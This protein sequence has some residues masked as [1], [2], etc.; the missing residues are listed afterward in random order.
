[1]KAE[2]TKILLPR[3]V[4]EAN[5]DKD[6]ELEATLPDFQPDINRVVRAD[7]EIFCEENA[8]GDGK[9]KVQ[10]KA[11]FTVLYES[12]SGKLRCEQFSSDFSHSFDTGVLPDG[13][14]SPT[15]SARCSFVSCKTLNPR[16]FLLRCRADLGLC[17]RCMQSHDVVSM[18]D[19]KDA[20]FKSVVL[21]N[22]EYKDTVRRDYNM[23]ESFSLE[24]M[25][26]IKEIVA[27]SMRF[28]PAEQSCN[29]GSLLLRCEAVFRCL[30]EDDTDTLNTVERRFP[31]VFTVEDPDINC[32][33]LLSV[34]VIPTKCN[35]H[36][37]MD[38]YGEYRQI[39]LE[40][41]AAVCVESVASTETKLP[42][43]MFFENYVNEN[44]YTDIPYEQPQR[45]TV[46]RFTEEKIFDAAE[47]LPDECLDIGTEIVIN[48]AI[49][50]ND[51]VTINGICNVSIFG[52]RDGAFCAKD[53][54][55]PFSRLIPTSLP[56]EE[57]RIKAK[58]ELVSATARAS[59]SGVTV[60]V[61]YQTVLNVS[62]NSF[63]RVISGADIE[64]RSDST[65]EA[66]MIICYPAP[67]E[68]AW[69][70]AKRYYVNPDVLCAENEDV[71][72]K[73]GNVSEAGK[74]I[75]I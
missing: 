59:G 6:I 5:A 12:D 66:P 28:L 73:D 35:A 68:S 41:S 51:G 38:A 63:V 25:P 19:S 27:C 61:E 10:G 40:Y 72:D 46:H 4:Y 43:D 64:K 45:P 29:T 70:I 50:S 14:L 48:E 32:D 18:A 34:K 54:S 42:T 30:Y 57:C 3:T 9:A 44:K 75:I 47:K 60:R 53:C 16:R 23:E 65:D 52:K 56:A 11:L 26:A 17:V 33:C 36:K 67:G 62:K 1:M 20:F 55:I 24:A 7:A 58:A 13:R 49:R 74:L 2:T 71:F 69:D 31:A 8:I 15:A 39:E 37:Q 22:A 21:Q